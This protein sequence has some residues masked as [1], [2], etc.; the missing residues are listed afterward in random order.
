MYV[1]SSTHDPTR[2]SARGRPPALSA[3]HHHPDSTPRYLRLGVGPCL[4]DRE[5]GH[6]PNSV[7]FT[8]SNRQARVDDDMPSTYG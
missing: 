1:M 7:A 8:A 2:C 6:S 3:R 5:P 4:A